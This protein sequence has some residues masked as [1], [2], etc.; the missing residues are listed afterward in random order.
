[1]A[2]TRD[3]LII[4]VLNTD[5]RLAGVL[6]KNEMHCLGCPSAQMESLGEAC[7]AHGIDADDLVGQLNGFLAANPA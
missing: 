4:E 3:S 5:E 6:M 2:I 7:A 1:M